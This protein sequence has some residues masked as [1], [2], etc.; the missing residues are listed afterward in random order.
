MK[1]LRSS[2]KTSKGWLEVRITWT[3]K[4]S[5]YKPFDIFSSVISA[6]A[7]KDMQN[8]CHFDE[9]LENYQRIGQWHSF[10]FPE[11][12]SKFMHD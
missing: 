2:S 12:S 4:L 5:N 6:F 9:P 10:N 8:N 7:D 1:V 3:E 11:I